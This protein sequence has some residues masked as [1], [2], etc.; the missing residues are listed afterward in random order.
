MDVK[1]ITS[2]YETKKYEPVK[3]KESKKEE[4][5]VS[6]EAEKGVV[7]EKSNEKVY[8]QDPELIAKLKADSEAR[9]AQMQ[10]LVNDML[11]KQGKTF[12]IA[13]GSNLKDLFSNL[14]VDPATV[15]QAQEDISEDGYWGVKQTSERMFDFA[16]ALSGGDPE[17]MEK[18]REAFEKGYAQAEKAWGDKLPEISQKTYEATQKLFD[19]YANQFKTE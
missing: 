13:N 2:T 12:D 3:N 8:K 14:K 17:K 5:A 19:E 6:K 1:G 4:S 15:K 9:V 18:M 10:K 7:Y 16:K 11:S